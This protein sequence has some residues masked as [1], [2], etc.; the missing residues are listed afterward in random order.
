LV[1]PGGALGSLEC[2]AACIHSCW[3]SHIDDP[4]HWRPIERRKLALWRKA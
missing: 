2:A 1:T 3:D 4:K